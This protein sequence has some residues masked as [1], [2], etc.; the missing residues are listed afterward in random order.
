MDDATLLKLFETATLDSLPHEYHLR[1]A[2]LLTRKYPLDQVSDVVLAG[3]RKLAPSLG[4]SPSS[5]HVTMTVAWTKVIAG[6]GGEG[7]SE[8]F[9]ALHPELLRRDMLSKYYSAGQ[10]HGGHSRTK[11]VAPDRLPFPH[12]ESDS[13]HSA[14]A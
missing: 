10:L 2:Y 1:I 14:E 3:F 7:T 5:I 12:R 13:I 6:L 8:E 4:L 9:I 11:F